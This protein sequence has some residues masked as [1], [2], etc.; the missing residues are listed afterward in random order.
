MGTSYD[1]KA[2][3]HAGAFF[4]ALRVP[5]TY[6]PGQGF[7]LPETFDKKGQGVDKG[8]DVEILP[9]VTYCPDCGA[10]WIGYMSLCPKCKSG[11]YDKFTNSINL[12]V[13]HAQAAVIDF[14]FHEAG[15]EPRLE[16]IPVPPGRVVPEE[17]QPKEAEPVQVTLGTALERVL[18]E[19][20]YTITITKVKE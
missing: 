9:A 10:T 6:T 1:S 7:Y 5:F 17:I 18:D 13:K 14:S 11:G 16:P 19:T 20:D 8:T 2:E 12:A 15:V 4:R 3:A